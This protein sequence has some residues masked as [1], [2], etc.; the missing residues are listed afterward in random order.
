MTRAAHQLRN[1][2]RLFELA[3]VLDLVLVL[4]LDQL[5]VVAAEAGG[6][7]VQSV[8][9]AQGVRWGQKG[10]SPE[11]AGSWLTC[12]HKQS[13]KRVKVWAAAQGRVL[14]ARLILRR[15]EQQGNIKQ[16]GHILLYPNGVYCQQPSGLWFLHPA[17]CG[18]E[19]GARQG[20][21][22][23]RQQPARAWQL[24]DGHAV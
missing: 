7:T 11:Y 2:Q 3:R 19:E 23:Q 16:K 10:N 24:R 18:G 4:R 13:H 21:I 14:P 1:L 5:Q 8:Q 9:E 17:A 22:R 20:V 12:E 15:M 6:G